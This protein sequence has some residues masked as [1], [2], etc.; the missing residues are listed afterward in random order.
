MT[1][2]QLYIS[3]GLPCLLVLLNATIMLYLFS[4]IEAR[5]DKLDAKI[6]SKVDGVRGEVDGLRS[7]LGA[8]I[9]GRV[10]SLRAELG[11]KLDKLAADYTQFYAEQSR[12]D[13]RL[14]ALE[15]QRP[16]QA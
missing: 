11:G 15:R 4:R 14:T 6:D 8:K 3:V 1:N 13:E 9:D 7:E 10:D 2:Q 16:P 12:H 5:M